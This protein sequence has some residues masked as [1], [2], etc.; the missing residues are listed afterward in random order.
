MCAVLDALI[1]VSSAR[2][3]IGGTLSDQ[4]PPH[5]RSS[6][7]LSS[8]EIARDPR[9]PTLLEKKKNIGGLCHQPHELSVVPSTFVEPLRLIKRPEFMSTIVEHG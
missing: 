5:A 4:M 1:G 7:K 8:T 9:H 3:A 2:F 6:N